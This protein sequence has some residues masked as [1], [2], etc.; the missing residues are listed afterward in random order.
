VK[1]REL[2]VAR[3]YTSKDRDLTRTVAE[4]AGLVGRPYP[5]PEPGAD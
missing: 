1:L 3:V 2:G 4:I 5:E